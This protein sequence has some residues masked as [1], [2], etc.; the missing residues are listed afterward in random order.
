[1]RDFIENPRDGYQALHA[2]LDLGH[3]LKVEVQVMKE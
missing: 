2:V 1:M 3:G